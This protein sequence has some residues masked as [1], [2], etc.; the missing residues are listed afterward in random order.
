ML[1]L[2][3]EHDITARSH[4]DF[5]DAFY[6]KICNRSS[7]HG[8]NNR[9]AISFLLFAGRLHISSLTITAYLNSFI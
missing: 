9:Q 7:V 8:V 1:T 5:I 3:I 2:C 4:L 6:Q